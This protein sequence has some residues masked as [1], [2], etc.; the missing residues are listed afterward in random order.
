M[1]KEKFYLISI[2]ILF[3]TLIGSCRGFTSSPM[4]GAD[5]VLPAD[6]PQGKSCGDGVCDGP[7]N[8]DTCPADCQEPVPSAGIE[9]SS[10]EAAISD[11]PP[12]YFFYAIHV[13]GS[14]EYL[15]YRDP[16]MTEVDPVVAENMLAAIEGIAGVLEKYG[17]RATWEFMA[18]TVQGLVEYQ[19]GPVIFERLQAAGH[20]IG[21]HGHR[22]EAVPAAAVAL[23]EIAGIDPAT[24]SGFLVQVPVSGEAQA[25]SAMSLVMRATVES[26]L[27]VGTVNF[28]PG[29]EMNNLSS[30]CGDQFGVG[31]DMYLETGNLMHPWHPDYL[32][33]DVCADFPGGKMTL[34]DHVPLTA[35]IL[36]GE[37]APPDVLGSQ[38][39][40]QLQVYFDNALGYLAENQSERLAAWGFVT[41]IIEYA[42][43]SQAENPPEESALEA[44]DGF[45][46]H[47]DAYHRQG[48]VIYATASEIA[49]AVNSGN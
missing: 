31:N 48:L 32:N 35:F 1:K 45:L 29:G 11:I 21:V 6:L 43:G 8:A 19:G 49:E 20:E 27:S 40:D 39:F 16:G 26:G 10:E 37:D 47:V 41:H 17:A 34:I 13:H 24:S 23:Q 18:P 4:P 2:V 30:V 9:S 7:E 3:L 28:T 33:E 5:G 15:P 42:V 12:L 44:L 22:L 14:K 38:H 46:S 36:P 25:Q